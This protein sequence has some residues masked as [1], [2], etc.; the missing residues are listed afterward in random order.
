MANILVIEDD[1][2][3]A[4][5]IVAILEDQ[6]H[7]LRTAENGRKGLDEVARQRPELIVLDMNMPVMDGFEFAKRFRGDPENRAIPILASTSEM[8]AASYDAA[9]DAGCDG[10]LSKPWSGKE[11]I[12][13]IGGFLK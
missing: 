1:E 5:L 2:I 7:T 4:Q 9:Y 12:E 3:M 10:Y 13:R 6:G 11:L 8:R